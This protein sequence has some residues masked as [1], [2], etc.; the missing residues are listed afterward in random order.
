MRGIALK[1]F[2]SFWLIQSLL[3][4]GFA[5]LPAPAR[6]FR[7]NEPLRDGGTVA[8][9]ILE[10]DGVPACRNF[11][12]LFESRRGLAVQLADSST[13]SVCASP[14]AG[15]PRWTPDATVLVTGPDGRNFTAHGKALP[16]FE[17]VSGRPPFPWG[18]VAITI[19]LSGIVCFALAA[20]LARPL[21]RMREVTYRLAAGDL[22]GRVGPS[23]GKR[24]DEIGDLVRD[25]DTMADRI[26]ALV[27]SQNQMLSDISHELRS[28][29]ARL[30][31]ALELARRKA[32]PDAQPDLDRLEAESAQMNDLIGRILELARA[33]NANAVL[34]GPVDLASVVRR[35]A[36]DADYEAQQESKAVMVHIDAQPE[37]RG[38][39]DLI[40]S[41]LE[42]V[43][44][45]AV[46]HT[47]PSS[48]VQIELTATASEAIVTVRDHGP[49]VA[50]SEV[51]RIFQPFHRVDQ[52]RNRGT[53][54]VGL[55]LAIARRAVSLHLGTITA[56]LPKDG[57]LL[58]TIRLPLASLLA[59]RAT[60]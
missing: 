10:R 40:T 16:S 9:A 29:L 26:E 37:V 46:R 60:S 30:N 33:E 39:I 56:S 54:G 52:A 36:D 31:V 6:S 7:L 19:I 38:S 53:G 34:V 44:R 42:N 24:R 43:L 5:F 50:P 35:V 59:A 41:A 22:Q 28:P 2:L 12:S 13:P 15:D 58:V 17:P 1:I 23:A 32:G 49:G 8:A 48:I 21:R 3:I 57:G 14:A 11:L 51:E 4:A 25:F 18:N 55:G 27:D 45:N 20:Y 47:P